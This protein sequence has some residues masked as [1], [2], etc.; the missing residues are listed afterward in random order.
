MKTVFW[1]I[2]LLGSAFGAFAQDIRIQGA[3]VPLAPPG[4]MAHAAYMTLEN[5]GE[6]PRSLVGVS[7]DGYAMAHLHQSMDHDGVATMS[8]VGQLEIAPGQAVMLEPGS[9][10]IMLMRPKEMLKAGDAVTIALEFA[11]GETQFVVALVKE[12]DSGS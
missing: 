5:T 3:Y 11:N 4:V 1:V 2:A 8:M 12:R 7:A 6:L 10:H 9:F